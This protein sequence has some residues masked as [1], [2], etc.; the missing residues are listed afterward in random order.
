MRKPAQAEGIYQVRFVNRYGHQCVTGHTD[1]TALQGTVL[2]V[3][4]ELVQPEF[5]QPLDTCFLNMYQAPTIVQHV[6]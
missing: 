1:D 5:H 6:M 3:S 4:N 2:C